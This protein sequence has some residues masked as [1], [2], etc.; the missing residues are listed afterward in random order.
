MPFLTFYC[1]GEDGM[2]CRTN[3]KDNLIANLFMSKYKV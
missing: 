3:I 2:K 1:P